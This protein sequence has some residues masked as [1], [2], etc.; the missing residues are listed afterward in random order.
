[1][2][3]KYWLEYSQIIGCLLDGKDLLEILLSSPGLE[4]LEIITKVDNVQEIV[5]PVD[6]DWESKWSNRYENI[7]DDAETLE[8][9][10][11]SNKL[12]S[13]GKK[14]YVKKQYMAQF[15][16]IYFLP[17]RLIRRYLDSYNS[18]SEEIKNQI[19][20]TEF[21]EKTILINNFYVMPKTFNWTEVDTIEDLS[22]AQE[23]F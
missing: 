10:L 15:M 8:Y 18:L 6:L 11:V 16:G 21:F 23:I 9:D 3:K 1:M 14:T 7:F 19:S 13:I 2:K 4:R 22:Y 12:L 5:I 17:K 20:T